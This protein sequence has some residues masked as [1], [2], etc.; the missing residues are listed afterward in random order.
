MVREQVERLIAKYGYENLISI[1]YDGVLHTKVERYKFIFDHANETVTTIERV[2]DDSSYKSQ[3]QKVRVELRQ[4][5]T[6]FKM[7]FKI[8]ST[9]AKTLL[10]APIN[11]LTG[12]LL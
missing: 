4:Y 6:I 12:E 7:S 11:S 1:E 10:D 9:E 2:P 3:D 5:G 8:P